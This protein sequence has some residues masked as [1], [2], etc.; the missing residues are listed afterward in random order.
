MRS[1]G[2][3]THVVLQVDVVDD[4]KVLQVHG[5]WLWSERDDRGQLQG[6]EVW[7]ILQCR[8]CPP[9]H[10]SLDYT[11]AERGNDL[12]PPLHGCDCSQRFDCLAMDTASTPSPLL[13]RLHLLF[14]LLLLNVSPLLLWSY[15]E[16][17][18]LLPLDEKLLE[19]DELLELPAAAK[20]PCVDS[21]PGRLQRQ[22]DFHPAANPISSLHFLAL[23]KFL[24]LSPSPLSTQPRFPQPAQHRTSSCK[25]ILLVTRA[26]PRVRWQTNAQGND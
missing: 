23:P 4:A 21:Q 12:G 14:F 3:L 18:E 15:G 25:P 19:D 24:S 7:K 6:L 1:S 9:V 8:V 2:V 13:S 22:Q 20:W 11:E 26:M 10:P 5:R 16:L 17:L